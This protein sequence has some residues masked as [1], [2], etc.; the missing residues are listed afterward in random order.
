MAINREKAKAAARDIYK[1]LNERDLNYEEVQIALM[2]MTAWDMTRLLEAHDIH[3]VPG[4]MWN[5]ATCLYTYIT[6]V[7]KERYPERFKNEDEDELQE[8]KY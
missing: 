3:R 7:L 6:G 2:Q 5:W 1:L 4:Y 8:L